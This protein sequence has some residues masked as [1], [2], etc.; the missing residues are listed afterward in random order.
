M[1]MYVDK[2]R[3]NNKLFETIEYYVYLYMLSWNLLAHLLGK[4][5]VGFLTYFIKHLKVCLRTRTY[6]SSKTWLIKTQ[7]GISR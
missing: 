2:E 7:E 1:Y 5:Y 6:A 4:A 3:K